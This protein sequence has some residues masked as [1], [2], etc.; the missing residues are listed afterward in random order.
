[1][2]PVGFYCP[3]FIHRFIFLRVSENR[4]FKK[5]FDRKKDEVTGEWRQLHNAEIC[6]L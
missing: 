5:V 2:H 3:E 1:V 4:V 6:D